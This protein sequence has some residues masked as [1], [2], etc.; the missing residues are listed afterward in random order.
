MKGTSLGFKAATLL[1]RFLYF[2]FTMSSLSKISFRVMSY[3]YVILFLGNYF[4][5][6]GNFEKL[7]KGNGNTVCEYNFVFRNNDFTN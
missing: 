4:S 7:S 2:L 6:S 3:F 1:S 5:M